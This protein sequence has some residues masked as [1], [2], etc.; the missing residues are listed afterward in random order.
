MI[1]YIFQQKQKLKS[2]SLQKRKEKRNYKTSLL[3]K[4]QCVIV[5][6]LSAKSEI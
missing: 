6:K 3:E 4:S 2:L 5:T 1:F